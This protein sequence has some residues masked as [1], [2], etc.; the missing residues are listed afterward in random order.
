MKTHYP[1]HQRFISGE[2]FL[3]ESRLKTQSRKAFKKIRS[4]KDSS[5]LTEADQHFHQQMMN[6]LLHSFFNTVSNKFI[7]RNESSEGHFHKENLN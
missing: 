1:N 3:M 2:F 4:W 5:L 7:L 6:I